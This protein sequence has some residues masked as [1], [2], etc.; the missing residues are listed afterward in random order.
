MEST[1]GSSRPSISFPLGLVLLIVVLVSISGFFSCCYSW[2]KIR[3]LLLQLARR[4][5]TSDNQSDDS[6]SRSIPVKHFKV[7]IFPSHLQNSINH[8]LLS[9]NNLSSFRRRNQENAFLRLT[10][11]DFYFLFALCLKPEQLPDQSLTV[12]M[13]G[14]EA[15][16]YL[17]FPAPRRNMNV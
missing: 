12:V 7:S 5:D 8:K 16:K 9:S 13:P 10:K 1:E 17:A 14:D 6:L 11:L 15:P 2:S 4:P 3:N